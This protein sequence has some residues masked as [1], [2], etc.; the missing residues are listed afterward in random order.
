MDRDMEGVDRCGLIARSMRVIG[1]MTSH[2]ALV[3]KSTLMEKSIRENGLMVRLMVGEYSLMLMGPLT[4]GIG[5][6]TSNTVMEK[7]DGLM[8]QYSQDII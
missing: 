6:M 3:G 8:I 7:K 1:R 5:R 4:M 2:M